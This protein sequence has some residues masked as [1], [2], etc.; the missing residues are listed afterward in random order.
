LVQGPETASILKHSESDPSV[1]FFEDAVLK[2]GETLCD[3]ANNALISNDIGLYTFTVQQLISKKA[4]I[5]NL[6]DGCAVS[7]F[8]AKSPE[9]KEGAAASRDIFEFGVRAGECQNRDFHG[10]LKEAVLFYSSD[11]SDTVVSARTVMRSI[12]LSGAKTGK[13]VRIVSLGNASI[14]VYE[15]QSQKWY[16]AKELDEQTLTEYLKG[17]KSDTLDIEA[18]PIECPVV[19]VNEAGPS[20]ATSS[21]MTTDE[22][23]VLQSLMESTGMYSIAPVNSVFDG[24][25]SM[26]FYHGSWEE[27]NFKQVNS[28]PVPTF[29]QVQKNLSTEDIS[30]WLLSAF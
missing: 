30:K 5:K 29:I 12:V 7:I 3:A 9:A 4:Y 18:S 13:G 17:E 6:I 23:I 14:M 25:K 16:I 28:N 15:N 1:F 20:V 8:M 11:D 21:K 22:K 24:V 2:A 27:S 26:C 10:V 19:V